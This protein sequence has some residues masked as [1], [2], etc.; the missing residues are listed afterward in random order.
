MQVLGYIRVMRPGS[1]LGPQQLFLKQRQAQ[2]WALGNITRAPA[3][4]VSSMVHPDGSGTSTSF[5]RGFMRS[6]APAI[7]ASP[8]LAPALTACGA[9]PR[10]SGPA[11]STRSK[12]QEVGS[13]GPLSSASTTSEADTS[14]LAAAQPRAGQQQLVRVHSRNEQTA[15]GGAAGAMLESSHVPAGGGHVTRTVAANGQPRKVVAPPAAGL[16]SSDDKVGAF[17]SSLGTRRL[18]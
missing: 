1:I 2:M 4:P 5:F 3:A 15:F 10:V 13:S 8:P 14:T 16:R 7:A 18:S 11:A 6:L 17:R 9:V 12:V